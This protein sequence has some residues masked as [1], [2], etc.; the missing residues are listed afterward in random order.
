[1]GREGKPT[2]PSQPGAEPRPASGQGVEGSGEAS[3][4]LLA[5]PSHPGPAA[6]RP[7][8]G[9][10]GGGAKAKGLGCS[11]QAPGHPA[12]PGTQGGPPRAAGPRAA[13]WGVRGGDALARRT[14]AQRG[15]GQTPY[16]PEPGA[17]SAR[18]D[19]PRPP[20]PLHSC[21]RPCTAGAALRPPARCGVRPAAAWSLAADELILR[22]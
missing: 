15:A 2:S 20:P 22:R 16:L 12:S 14:G 17:R 6:L 1:M 9:A 5:P 19:L 13:C 11:S 21:G 10:G 3:R 7:V 18:P 8:L 4:T